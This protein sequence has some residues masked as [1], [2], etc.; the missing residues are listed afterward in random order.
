MGGA[1]RVHTGPNGRPIPCGNGIPLGYGIATRLGHSTVVAYQGPAAR[2]SSQS[3]KKTAL[4]H[5][6]HHVCLRQRRPCNTTSLYSPCPWRAMRSAAA[7]MPKGRLLFLHFGLL[8]DRPVLCVMPSQSRPAASYHAR[9]RCGG[10]ARGSH[11]R[12]VDE[13]RAPQVLRIVGL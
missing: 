4:Q 2:P 11:G 9:M 10:A 7:F 1:R 8:C 5:A 12:T 3:R 6:H 13:V